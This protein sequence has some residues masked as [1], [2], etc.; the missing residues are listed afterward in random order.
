MEHNISQSMEKSCKSFHIT[1]KNNEFKL[2]VTANLFKNSINDYRQ[3]IEKIKLYNKKR[4]NHLIIETPIRNWEMSLRR[5]RN[6]I[7]LRKG[8]LNISSDTKPVWIIAT[9]RCGVDEE[10]I[11]NPDD[12][13]DEVIG[14]MLDTLK[15]GEKVVLISDNPDS[16][17]YKRL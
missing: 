12:N 8:Y 14:L 11:V 16:D 15:D 5:P 3:K 10:K 9:E 7:G 6:F 17:L 13:L 1:N 4:K 2:Y